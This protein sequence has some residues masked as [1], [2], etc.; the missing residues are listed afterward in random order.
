MIKELVTFFLKIWIFLGTLYLAVVVSDRYSLVPPPP[1]KWTAEL[2]NA[3][4]LIDEANKLADKAQPV[5]KAASDVSNAVTAPLQLL[6]QVLKAIP[7]TSP[8]AG[9]IRQAPE[10]P[11]TPPGPTSPPGTSGGATNPP[12]STL[13]P[14]IFDPSR[15]VLQ[16]PKFW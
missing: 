6:T 2:R 14:H 15:G 1:A 13:R 10:L 16:P 9:G 8:G 7:S 5:A 12:P 4:E 11:I 3:R